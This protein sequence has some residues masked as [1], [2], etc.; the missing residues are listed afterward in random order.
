MHSAKKTN[1]D[2]LKLY[3][4][5]KTDLA[6]AISAITNAM[7]TL[8]GSKPSLLQMQ[9]AKDSVQEVLAMADALGMGVDTMQ[10]PM[11]AL[12]QQAPEVEME[13][14]KFHSNGVIGTLET[15]LKDFRTRKNTNDS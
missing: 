2:E 7:A 14:Y 8:K 1:Q 9:S 13:N 12:L 5:R 10:G 6:N 15:L 4:E 3:N 11:A